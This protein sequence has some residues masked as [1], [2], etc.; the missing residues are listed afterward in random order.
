ME[1]NIS[2]VNVLGPIINVASSILKKHPKYNPG[3][4][5]KTVKLILKELEAMEFAIHMMIAML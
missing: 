2:V 5:W 3:A 1:N 4:M